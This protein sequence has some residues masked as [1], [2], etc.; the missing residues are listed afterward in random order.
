M[1]LGKKS[2]KLS[3]V[4]VGDS[5]SSRRNQQM[6]R[7][8]N[9]YEKICDIENLYLAD[10]K[11]SKGKSMMHGVIRHRR[12]RD[13]NLGKLKELLQNGNFKTSEYKTFKIFD[14][15]EREI[16]QLPYF[17]DRI[18]HHAVM[19]VLEPIF[20]SIFTKDT[21]SCIK[22]RGI[23]GVVKNIR[24]ALS[25]IEHSQYCLKLDIRKFYPS[26]NHDI[27]KSIIRRKIKDDRLLSLLDDIIDS[28][29][30]VPIGNYL[31]QYFANLYLA[32][33]DHWVKEVLRV[34]YYFRYAD[35]IVIL[36]ADKGRLH[37]LCFEIRNYLWDKL[38]LEVKGNWQVFPVSSRG[39]DF[40]GYVFYHT[41]TRMRKRIKKRFAKRA[42][43]LNKKGISSS[44][45]GQM[46]SPW[47]GWA[48][49]CDGKHLLKKLG[50]NKNENQKAKSG[51]TTDARP[52]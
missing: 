49:H 44:E 30:G 10:E 24:K 41:H 25:D 19:N 39:I 42:S 12:N 52:S 40:V 46:L 35:D 20:V 48:K 17:P 2:R 21:Y 26:I 33:F 45:R 50:L 51:I 38:R 4:S 1:P 31:S 22:G 23:H 9:L 6:K 34:K 11:A 43:M 14:P 7:I 28:A 37:E 29:P 3:R 18:V 32:Y 47:V 5:D 8:G 36:D 16:Y 15:K 27:L 13:E